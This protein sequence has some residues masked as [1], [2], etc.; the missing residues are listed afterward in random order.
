MTERGKEMLD[1]LPFYIPNGQGTTNKSF[2][3]AL[4]MALDGVA[5][6]IEAVDVANTVQTAQSIEELT[7]LGALVNLPPYS[8]EAIEHYRTRI[9]VWFKLASSEGT[10]S[11]VMDT[12]VEI[13]PNLTRSEIGYAAGTENGAC[14]FS[15][16]QAKFDQMPVSVSELSM[17][18]NNT[19][20]AAFRI[21]LQ[22]A[23]GTFTYRTVGGTNDPALGY[24][25]GT[26]SGIIGN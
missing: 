10:I 20:A 6:D 25:N 11:D 22:Y 1:A 4:G 3:D 9:M 5:A 14:L 13:I 12:L 8:G 17:M 7:K 15:V 23:Q 18:L 24:N 2:L 26:Y 19:T 21:A 16:P